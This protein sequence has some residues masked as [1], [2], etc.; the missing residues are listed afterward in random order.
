MKQAKDQ[1]QAVLVVSEKL[2]DITED[3][4]V[5]PRNHLILVESDRSVRVEPMDID[6]SS[7]P[8]K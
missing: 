1:D 5:I 2:T 6:F 3:W 4:Q 8:P 7:D